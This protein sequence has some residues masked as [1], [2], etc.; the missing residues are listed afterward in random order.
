MKVL[1]FVVEITAK[2]NEMKNGEKINNKRHVNIEQETLEQGMRR[3]F[4]V[5]SRRTE[6]SA[7]MTEM[8]AKPSIRRIKKTLLLHTSLVSG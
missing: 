3:L 4:Y 7:W 1:R 8:R 6:N 5:E 2:I